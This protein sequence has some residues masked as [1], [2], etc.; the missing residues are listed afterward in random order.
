MFCSEC[1]NR[2]DPG[3]QFC[4]SCGA[5]IEAAP[6]AP[7][8]GETAP[9]VPTPEAP[10]PGG[11]S[12]L[13]VL[14]PA[15]L[16]AAVLVA[17]IALLANGLGGGSGGASSPD[18]AVQQLANAVQQRDAAA[19]I[20]VIDP[21]EA[22]TLADVYEEV[23][24]D[25]GGS[26]TGGGSGSAGS[27]S[28]LDISG[29]RLQ[30]EQVGPGVARVAI[31]AGGVRGLI[32]AG[33]L[34]GGILDSDKSVDF[35]FADTYGPAGEGWY[36][37]TREVD[38]RWYVSPTMT[39]LQY[40][41]DEGELPSPDFA[42]VSRDAGSAA[43]TSNPSELLSALTEA[44]NARDV[45]QLLDLVS[46][47][48]AA[49][50]RPYLGALQALLNEVDGAAEVQVADSDFH[51]RDIGSGLVRLELSHAAFDAYVSDEYEGQQASVK[52]NGL[53]LNALSSEGYGSDSC[54]SGFG[55]TF[56]VNSFFVVARREDGGLRLA[57]IATV[58][59]YAHLLAEQLGPEG[60]RRA[61]GSLGHEDGSVSP[62]SPASGRLSSAGS[63]VLSYDAPSPGLLALE[64]NQYLALYDPD[65]ALVEPLGC[66]AGV[67]FYDLEDAG[68]YHVV[69]GSGE[70]ETGEYEV[71]AEPLEA[72][73]I[74]LGESVSGVTGSGIGA[75]AFSLRFEEIKEEVTFDTDAPVE[76]WLADPGDGAEYCAGSF[77][78][79]VR[80]VAGPLS[81][82]EP[83][84]PFEA[85]ELP[86][87]GGNEAYAYYFSDSEGAYLL[88]AGSPGT[89][90]NGS[91]SV[92]SYY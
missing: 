45:G 51:Q 88:I 8:P 81:L 56:G 76:I 36:V 90:F 64:G 4:S 31:S 27:S 10:A 25:L 23:H 89:S 1:G 50:V 39:A 69:V 72:P 40:L 34:P 92:D 49:A 65:G 14:L 74:G 87:S 2:L 3:D 77:Q 54:Q 86:S 5:A 73:E 84:P 61:T 18:D 52:V 16:G 32:K 67:Q 85:T 47:Q 83:L 41:V 6:A 66:P 35:Q 15:A 17:V 53:C 59:E 55:R 70:Y 24:A 68:G 19:A 11:R 57:P 38:G 28:D 22:A 9:A 37:M 80:Q 48:E 46:N 58:L 75:A 79:A 20:A 26:A 21:E 29:L 30:D 42:A 91:F 62:G 60:V 44:L 82:L 43:S 33:A 78:G 13:W 7:A 71:R 12:R 63:A